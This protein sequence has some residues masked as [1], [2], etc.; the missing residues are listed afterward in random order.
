MCATI[1]VYMYTC[2]HVYMYFRHFHAFFLF[3]LSWAGT[4]QVLYLVPQTPVRTGQV[5]GTELDHPLPGQ[6]L[7]VLQAA[8]HPL[9][10]V[11]GHSRIQ[12][13][14]EDYYRVLSQFY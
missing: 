9:Q 2:I 1:I 4:V 7:A 11:Q 13:L 6:L 12:A 3:S 14:Q 10:V 5:L 8:P